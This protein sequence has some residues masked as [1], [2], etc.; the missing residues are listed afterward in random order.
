MKP[1]EKYM[2]SRARID[3]NTMDFSDN[4]KNDSN[5]DLKLVPFT[6]QLP[7]NVLATG[8]IPVFIFDNS[9]KPSNI[10][11][12]LSATI[13]N[14]PMGISNPFGQQFTMPNISNLDGNT[15]GTPSFNYSN[16]LMGEQFT[17]PYYPAPSWTSPNA[18]NFYYG[19]GTMAGKVGDM[20]DFTGTMT[21]NTGA[22]TGNAGT[23]AGN[24]GT[25]TGNTGTMADNIGTMPGN[26][27]TMA[28]NTGTMG[29]TNEPAKP[30]YTNIP[31]TSS[32]PSSSNY[33]NEFMSTN[34]NAT[35]PPSESLTD[36]FMP[37]NI[38]PTSHSSPRLD[39]DITEILRNFNLDLDEDL[40]LTRVN[41][42]KRI[43]N[44]FSTISTKHPEV[45]SLLRA[46][47]IPFPIIKLLIRRII[48]L[49]LTHGKRT[50]E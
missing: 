47:N 50:D 11:T 23:M 19:T 3:D 37:S 7:Y 6:T 20:T 17:N 14:S 38:Q 8:W 12:N 24:T 18:P 13:P 22:M 36:N 43:D 10:S 41:S 16:N 45:I 49:S 30:Y 29:G 27:G 2:P 40:D 9:G 28:S 46:Y 31:G 33:E 25:M 1:D 4:D 42:D 48:K 5:D 32:V 15:L 44:I 26:T 39:S 34:S 35:V 21:G